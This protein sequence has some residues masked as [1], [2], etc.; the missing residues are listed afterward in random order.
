MA[1]K[2]LNL[3]ESCQTEAVSF[4][5]FGRM[6]TIHCGALTQ[7]FMVP[8]TPLYLPRGGYFVYDLLKVKARTLLSSGLYRVVHVYSSGHRR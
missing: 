6:T 2:W 8:S 3:P 4:R 5:H 7:R 1:K